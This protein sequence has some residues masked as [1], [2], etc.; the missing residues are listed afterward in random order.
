MKPT[1][2]SGSTS[3]GGQANEHPPPTGGHTMSTI[4]RAAA[5]HAEEVGTDGQDN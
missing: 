1:E 3:A 5:D 4:N 2:S